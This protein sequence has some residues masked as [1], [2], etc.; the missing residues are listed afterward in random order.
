MQPDQ[1]NA[2]NTMVQVRTLEDLADL[3]HID[4][5]FAQVWGAGVPVL[6]VELL[7]AITHAG[8]HAGGAFI[9][10]VLVG[11]SAAFL[12]RHHGRLTLHSH[13]TGVLAQARGLHIGRALKLHQRQWA[14]DHGI[15]LITWTFD[16][17]IRRNAWFNI[18]RLGAL[19]VEYLIDFYGPMKDEI[20][21]GEESDRLLVAW[22]LNN[23]AD[24]V[25]YDPTKHSSIPT[26][27]DI[28]SMRRSDP[29]EARAW[30]QRL[31]EQL[32]E[33]VASGRVVGFTRENGYLVQAAS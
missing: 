26:P 16:P 2:P 14:L 18:A 11:A 27:A 1:M 30:R 31:R 9:D 12:G 5:V 28:E 20:N 21:V 15:D 32:R 3:D 8:G 22:E 7:R 10:G 6:G 25:T 29:T 23:P 33:L 17:L 4:A 24:P 13:A 19:P